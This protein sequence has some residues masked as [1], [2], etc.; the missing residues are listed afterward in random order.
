MLLNEKTPEELKAE[1]DL[2]KAKDRL[3]IARNEGNKKRRKE[4]DRHKYMMGGAI[5]KYFPEAYEFSEHE[6]NR[7]I[8][9][10]AKNQGIRNLINIVVNDRSKS[11]A[12]SNDA[13]SETNGIG[14]AENQN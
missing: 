3:Q 6:V 1:E 2:R 5:V 8:A 11:K 10:A 14:Q 12:E 9:G 7:V 13:S 4:Q